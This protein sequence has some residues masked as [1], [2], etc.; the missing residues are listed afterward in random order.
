MPRVDNEGTTKTAP[1]QEPEPRVMEVEVTLNLIN[2]KMNF[3]IGKLEEISN[4]LKA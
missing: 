2:Q 1:A 4:K 3:M